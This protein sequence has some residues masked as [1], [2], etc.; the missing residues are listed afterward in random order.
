MWT[1]SRYYPNTAALMARP[2]GARQSWAAVGCLGLAWAPAHA[3]ASRDADQSNLFADI[4][5]LCALPGG[6][7]IPVDGQE[8][9]GTEL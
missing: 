8:H 4:P 1:E 7:V 5:W 6:K 2:V 9:P 3:Q